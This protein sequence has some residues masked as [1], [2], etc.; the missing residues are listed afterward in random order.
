MPPRYGC[1]QLRDITRCVSA[2]VTKGLSSPFEIVK[3]SE[4]EE[5][6]SRTVFTLALFRQRNGRCDLSFISS[7][8]VAARGPSIAPR[9]TKKS[10]LGH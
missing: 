6:I 9:R 4:N 3:L 5:R 8:G 2:L 1:S 7:G 10:D